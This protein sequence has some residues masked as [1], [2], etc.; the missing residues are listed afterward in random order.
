MNPWS[1]SI[2]ENCASPKH[3]LGGIGMEV[4]RAWGAISFLQ[5][6]GMRHMHYALSYFETCPQKSSNDS[7]GMVGHGRCNIWS[8]PAAYTHSWGCKISMQFNIIQRSSC[9][10]AMDATASTPTTTTCRLSAVTVS[11]RA[12][13]ASASQDSLEKEL[14]AHLATLLPIMETSTRPIAPRVRIRAQADLEQVLYPSANVRRAAVWFWC[15]IKWHVAAVN[16]MPWGMK[17]AWT[18]LSCTWIVLRR[19]QTCGQC[20][21]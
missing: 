13:C 12:K 17:S 18:A 15:A 19:T 14:I 21:H 2:N 5:I 10:Q 8:T 16:R 6:C 3:Y 4:R 11:Y 1:C 9:V 7:W 20:L